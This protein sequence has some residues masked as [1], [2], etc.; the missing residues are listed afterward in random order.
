VSTEHATLERGDGEQRT[1]R[2]ERHL[3]HGVD[4]VWR[5]VTEPGELAAWFPA[6]VIYEQR[7]GAPMQFDFGGMHGQDVWP[8][9]VLEWDPP[10]AFAFRWGTDDLRFVLEPGAD[11][12]TTILIFTHTFAHEPGK[13]A[14]DA[15][16]WESCLDELLQHLGGGDTVG[17]G[18]TTWAAHHLDYLGRFGDLTVGDRRVRL[19]GPPRDVGDRRGIDVLVGEGDEPG[20]LVGAAFADGAPV[21]ILTG[22]VESPGAVVA[23]GTLHDPLA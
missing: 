5:A 15:A 8:G 12:D 16:G 18:G 22:S 13:P 11:S 17:R 20:V 1:L 3:R 10:R 4:R 14:R 9:E 7:A 21:E 19:Q 6:A 2:F 23:T